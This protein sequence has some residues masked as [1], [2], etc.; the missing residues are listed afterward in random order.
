V[1]GFDGATGKTTFND[2]R[3]A[4]KQLFLLSV[5]R[6]GVKEITPDDRPGKVGG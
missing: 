5:E 2:Q 1:K 4:E 6:N 3:E